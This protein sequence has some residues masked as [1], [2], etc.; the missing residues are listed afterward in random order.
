MS[1]ILFDNFV[2][3][4]ILDEED[5]NHHSG[6]IIHCTDDQ[7]PLTKLRGWQSWETLLKAAKVRGHAAILRLA[8]EIPD[9]SFPS[10]TYHRSC[11]Q[12]FARGYSKNIFQHYKIKHWSLFD[13]FLT[14]L[15]KPKTTVV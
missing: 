8:D 5:E 7:S 15:K 1:G 13:K 9:G 3:N 12:M 14:L 2:M 6:C 4:Y 11:R 10:I